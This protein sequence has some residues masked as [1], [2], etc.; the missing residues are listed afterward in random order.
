ML[1]FIAGTFI[2]LIFIRNFINLQ[3]SEGFHDLLALVMMDLQDPTM[4]TALN[5]LLWLVWL[6]KSVLFGLRIGSACA[7]LLA[8]RC[9]WQRYAL[10]RSLATDQRVKGPDIAVS[11]F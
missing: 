6:I 3:G 5:P 2:L 11:W 7:C 9:H 8:C 10:A 1:I 4:I